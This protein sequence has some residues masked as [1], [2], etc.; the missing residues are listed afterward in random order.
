MAKTV[1]TRVAGT[2]RNV[3]AVSV[4]VSGTWRNCKQVYV[5][6]AGV[7][8]ELLSRGFNLAN[9]L[10][11]YRITS[12]APATQM[13]LN[14]GVWM[15]DAGTVLIGINRGTDELR[16]YTLSTPWDVSTAS[17]SQSVN[18]QA[19][20][21]EPY[22]IWVSPAGT[23]L[24][25][26]GTSPDAIHRFT[27]STALDLS[28]LSYTGQSITLSGIEW[29]SVW[30]NPDGTR[31]YCINDSFGSSDL[32]QYN[33]PTAFSLSGA[34]LAHT[35][36]IGV[37]I[38]AGPAENGKFVLLHSLG[39]GTLNSIKAFECGTAWEISTIPTF[40]SGRA[41]PFS[42]QNINFIDDNDVYDNLSFHKDG[43]YVYADRNGLF[44]FER[45]TLIAQSGVYNSSYE[46]GKGIGALS[47]DG[48]KAFAFQSNQ[49]LEFSLSTAFDL[50][51]ISA[52]PVR[53]FTW[54]DSLYGAL[55]HG[56]F[57]NNGST[58]LCASVQDFNTKQKFLYEYSLGTPYV[59]STL[60]YTGRNID[61]S[62]LV[63]G[64]DATDRFSVTEKNSG[65]QDIYF[66]VV[67]AT[68]VN[69]YRIIKGTFGTAYRPNTITV[70]QQSPA[71][72]RFFFGSNLFA[73]K[74]FTHSLVSPDGSTLALFQGASG[75]IQHFEMSPSGDLSSIDFSQNNFVSASS[76]NSASSQ[77]ITNT[78]MAGAWVG[79]DGDK[80]LV[81]DPNDY[82]VLRDII[83]L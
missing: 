47:P 46:V 8:K 60:S 13:L 2:W 16:K 58:L 14:E 55:Q 9:S 21:N 79:E 26:I 24:Y 18:I 51:T 67:S 27:M 36:D 44:M 54:N 39:T 37:G 33:L 6:V 4:K 30:L 75:V 20:Q 48:T 7:W 70:S 65:N 71:I 82:S 1:Q 74:P 56:Q 68:D 38:T 57:V 29:R 64:Y 52:T 5:K 35:L 69:D 53:T 49:I 3:K 10:D 73:T 32:R 12:F 25:L 81:C 80:L 43:Q 66:P 41:A 23:N 50:L 59:I 72:P 76:A 31:L 63:A 78:A 45:S 19:T 17:F 42:I 22:G 40:A 15:N 83:P 34:T 61:L 11:N 62:T 28:T 77:D